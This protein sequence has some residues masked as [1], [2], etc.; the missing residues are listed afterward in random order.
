MVR[1]T[2]LGPALLV[3]LAIA[4]LVL[5][6]PINVIAAKGPPE[7]FTREVRVTYDAQSDYYPTEVVDELDNIHMVWLNGTGR[8]QDNRQVQ[9]G[10]L[11][12]AKYSP[13]GDLIVSPT[14]LLDT[15]LD[16]GND[17]TASPPAAAIYQNRVFVTWADNHDKDVSTVYLI[18]LDLW[19]H[20]ETV[21]NTITNTTDAKYPDIAVD[22]EG[23]IH[24]AWAQWEMLGGESL[25]PDIYY[26]KLAQD[27]KV[28]VPRVT[29]TTTALAS[30][31][32]S[33]AVDQGANVHLVFEENVNLPGPTDQLY[34]CI[35]DPQGHLKVSMQRLTNTNGQSLRPDI[36]FDRNDR[37]HMVWEENHGTQSGIYYAVVGDP[38]HYPMLRIS[39]PSD[40][41]Y[42]ARLVMYNG[43]DT[44]IVWSQ[45]IWNGPIDNSRVWYAMVGAGGSVETGP[46]AL[47]YGGLGAKAPAIAMDG[48]GNVIVAWDDYRKDPVIGVDIWD[49][50]Y[51]RTVI[52]VNLEPIDVMEV[53][54][55]PFSGGDLQFYVNDDVVFFA[56]NSTDPNAWDQVVEYNFTVVHVNE[57]YYTGWSENGTLN[58]R[59]LEPGDYVVYVKVKDT[60]GYK[61]SRPKA[62]LAKVVERRPATPVPML[63]NPKLRTTVVASGIGLV[64]T[65]GYLVAGT[66]VGKY[67]FMTLLLVP[68]YSRIKRENTLD[69]YIR[70]QIHGYILAK[71]GCH[72]N[73]IKQT[74][75][76][77]NG[78][79][80]YHLRKLEREEFIKSIRDGMYKRF[81]PVGLKIPKREIKL[82]AMQERILDIIRHHPGISQKEV[83]GEVG[84]SA[85]AVIY[86][87]G[88]LA[89]AKLVRS[90]KVGSRM[91]YRALERPEDEWELPTDGTPTGSG[92]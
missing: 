92:H 57:T 58:Y 6:L 42:D 8:D 71:P 63:D 44:Q 33:I 10:Q 83:A 17:F 29:V 26:M 85:P 62:A 35:V 50:Y 27:G 16:N 89:G 73:Q 19:G 28:L 40:S 87:I 69:N 25:Y 66:E 30:N 48:Y 31:H 32:P 14:K 52:G 36:A 70:G 46:T 21:V 82:S 12:Y 54:G 65:L 41:S 18:R 84:I 49:I 88:V 7:G 24:L 91:E 9:N 78:T 75:N 56:G 23:D 80:A 90:D 37:L 3:Y 22:K 2:R 60:F 4:L 77:N 79:L 74:L 81:Y 72:Y 1:V 55:V 76:L 64:A 59:F 51:M 68:L 13:Y 86:H 47:T 43:L 53:N 34:Y 67:K 39:G 5:S 38:G 11:Y 61:N 20:L 15:V 45:N